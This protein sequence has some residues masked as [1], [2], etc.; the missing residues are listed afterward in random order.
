MTLILEAKDLS[1]EK[2]EIGPL[3][4]FVGRRNGEGV[5][6]VTA[7]DLFFFSW[8]SVSGNGRSW[9]KERHILSRVSDIDLHTHLGM[10]IRQT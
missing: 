3:K 7:I 9:G 5:I 1:F 8:V 2:A 6:Q 10:S 4:F